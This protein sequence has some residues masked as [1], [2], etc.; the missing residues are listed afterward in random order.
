VSLIRVL[1]LVTL[2]TLGA[3]NRLRIEQYGPSLRAEGIELDVSPFF[4]AAAHEVLY[5]PGHQ[6]AKALGV[7]RGFARRA[8]DV[9]R[10]RRYDLVLV[11]RESAPLGPPLVEALLG[12]L[13]VPY[14]YDFDDA[15]FVRPPY[16]ANRAW[17][18]LRPPSRV[19]STARGA[20]AVIVGNE[21]LAENARRWNERVTII[22]TP[23]DTE[24]HRPRPGARAAG[25]LVLGW[26][27]SQTTAPYLRLIDDA[28]TDLARR[29]EFVVRV[30]GGPYA[31]PTVRV[32]QL[33]YD[34]DREPADLESFDIGLLPEP[35]DSWTRGKGAFKA[36]LYMAT[37]IPVV[38]SR[39]GVN[40]EVVAEGETGFNVETT[41]Q[42]VQV[43]EKLLTDAELRHR[44]GGGGRQRLLD[45]YSLRVQAPRLAK[46]LRDAVARS[47]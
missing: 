10:A 47:E 40:P 28:L 43:L 22:P 8:R 23:V 24:R 42:W 11:Y 14:V 9:A 3:G 5:R 26:V 39:V 1:A 13:R 30:V 41:E 4:D 38:A 15:I 16:S 19:A 27:G 7:L 12:A 44:L 25:P 35:D 31:H 32:E 17:D 2:P 6:V 33:S 29:H 46:V 18:W 34:L 36:L 20:R 37:G 45:R 21:Y